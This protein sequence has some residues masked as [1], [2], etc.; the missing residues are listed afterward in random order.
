MSLVNQMHRY[1]K[2]LI[3]LHFILSIWHQRQIIKSKLV[4]NFSYMVRALANTFLATLHLFLLVFFSINIH[5]V[6]HFLC[7]NLFPKQEQNQKK[8]RK[9]VSEVSKEIEW[10]YNELKLEKKLGAIEEVEQAECQSLFRLE[11]FLHWIWYIF[12]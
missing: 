10:Y 11:K 1:L 8:L 12:I 2:N 3:W 4:V 7:V 5:I 9:A 6:W